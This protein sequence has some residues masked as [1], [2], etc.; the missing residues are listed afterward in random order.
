MVPPDGDNGNLEYA[1]RVLGI[2]K[3]IF[4]ARHCQSRRKLLRLF[5]RL[6]CL[7]W[8]KSPWLAVDEE[9]GTVSRLAHL[10]GPIPSAMAVGQ[11]AMPAQLRLALR[12]SLSL[13][14]LGFTVNLAPVTDVLRR[15]DN[16]C[17]ATRAFGYSSQNVLRGSLAVCRAAAASGM[18]SCCKHF[19]GLGRADR[20]SH[21]ALPVS[22]WP[23]RSVQVIAD[24]LQRVN[25]PI[26]MAGHCLYPNISRELT[27]FS[28]DLLTSFLRKRMDFKGVL[29][30]DDML[31][32]ALQNEPVLENRFLRA[33]RAG[34][35]LLLL[36]RLDSQVLAAIT[37]LTQ[38]TYRHHLPLDHL[39]RAR[40][41]LDAAAELYRHSPVPCADHTIADSQF[42]QLFQRAFHTGH[43]ARLRQGRYYLL[44]D[45]RA[46]ERCKQIPAFRNL[47]LR[48]RACIRYNAHGWIGFGARPATDPMLVVSFNPLHG[49]AAFCRFINQHRQFSVISLGEPHERHLFSRAAG[50][51]FLYSSHEAVVRNG[52]KQF[53]S[54][55]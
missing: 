21:H 25:V 4:F 15:Y 31:M 1:T 30:S 7:C 45:A 42:F 34:I 46:H 39:R 13:K 36:S 29:L 41:R 37:R 6:R 50:I 51:L 10:I 35:D 12:V 16:S 54:W 44:I 55:H 8:P 19:P 33:W 48:A 17:I 32:G 47:S 28:A 27:T 49:P 52:L 18:L 43:S 40:Q 38:P 20:D 53:I 9:G 2:N 26:I 14:R 24:L 3:F 22:V 5:H 23:R 11:L